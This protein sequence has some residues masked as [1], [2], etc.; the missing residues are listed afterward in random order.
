M[1]KKIL[2]KLYKIRWRSK[3]QQYYTVLTFVGVMVAIL[4]LL[5]GQDFGITGQAYKVFGVNVQDC[6]DSDGG[7]D[8]STAGVATVL[9]EYGHKDTYSDYCFH[10]KLLMEF[11]CSGNELVKTAYACRKATGNEDAVCEEGVC[12]G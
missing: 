1:V 2:K 5:E 4:M 3:K 9:R 6:L 12:V 10:S 11:S 7:D 8:V